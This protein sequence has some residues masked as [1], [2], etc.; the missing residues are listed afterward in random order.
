V[1]AGASAGVFVS[2]AGQAPCEADLLEIAEAQARRAGGLLLERYRSGVAEH[3]VHAKSTPTDLVSDADIDAERSIRKGIE[4]LRPDD[5]IL[6]EEGDDRPGTTGLR[7]VVDP[8]DG[9]VDFL[10]GIPHWC[11]SVA[12]QDEDGTVAGAVFDPLRGELFAGTRGGEA[13]LG[14]RPLRASTCADLASAMIATGFNYDASVRARQAKVLLE[15]LPKARDIRRFGAAALDL[16]WTAAGRFDAFYERGV[17]LWDVAAGVLL[18]ERAGLLVRELPA[19][20]G[21]PWGVL[22]APPGLVEELF[23]LVGGG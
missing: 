9:T 23:G 11:V 20:D 1:G 10:F 16:A 12:V 21:L 8:L 13:R 18:C 17:H 22:A 14:D 15:L 3:G 4:E 5:A 6:G 2:G 19:R 7:W